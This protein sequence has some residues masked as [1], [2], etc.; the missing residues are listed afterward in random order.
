VTVKLGRS[1]GGCRLAVRNGGTLPPNYDPAKG[2][3]FGMQMV[4]RIVDQLNGK[5]EASSMGGETEFAISFTPAEPQPT[6]LT[7]VGQR[8]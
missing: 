6:I 3:G 4:S 8:A 5:L 7:V 2:T 1:T